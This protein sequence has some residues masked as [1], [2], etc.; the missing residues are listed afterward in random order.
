MNLLSPKQ[1]RRG[2]AV[3]LQRMQSQEDIESTYTRLSHYINTMGG[4]GRSNTKL[5]FAIHAEFRSM[6]HK[7][8]E[9]KD[10]YSRCIGMLKE[11]KEH[12]IAV[13]TDMANQLKVS[14]TN[15]D[16]LRVKLKEKSKNV[17]NYKTDAKSKSKLIK[18]LHEEIATLKLQVSE[19][20]IVVED[21]QNTLARKEAVRTRLNSP[22][23]LHYRPNTNISILLQQHDENVR[24]LKRH[25]NNEIEQLR[26]Q[27]STAKNENASLK[28][29]IDNDDVNVV[30]ERSLR[31][32]VKMTEEKLV[33]EQMNCKELNEQWER[34]V[35]Q[36]VEEIRSESEGKIKSYRS[37]I[38]KLQ[39]E[40]KILR[41]MFQA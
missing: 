32:R 34:I 33:K 6:V 9:I 7:Y 31:R 21:L 3:P 17:D 14:E 1:S 28:K 19:Q 38:K 30:M 40:L 27:L 11:L 16:D 8:N 24:D 41:G 29:L 35:N 4:N 39:N 23:P 36:R 15:A 37:I 2:A 12:N 22:P 25:L 20:K 5:E 18:T 26:N 13:H 10:D